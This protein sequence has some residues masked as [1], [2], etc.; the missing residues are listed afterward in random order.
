MKRL[1]I[2]LI[3]CI[4]LAGCNESVL[5]LKNPAQYDESTYYKT[6]NECQEAVAACYSVL[7]MRPFYARDWYFIFDL[8][9][10]QS[11]KTANLEAT[12]V[13]FEE[14]TYAPEND[15]VNWAW[16]GFYR[17]SM[18]ALVAIEKIEAW[19]AKSEDEIAYKEQLL[20]EAY[21]FHG[22]AYY[23]LSE[24][25]GDVPYHPSWVSIKEEPSKARMPYA[26][27]Q[28]K[29]EE[30]L[31]TAVAKLPESWNT[32][33]LG[34]VTK[35]AARAMLGKLYL[36]QGK[37]DEAIQTLNSIK[38]S[39]LNGDYYSLFTRGNHTS[40]EIIFQVLHKFWGW[41]D[42]NSY[43]MWGGKEGYGGKATN[44]GRHVEYGFNDWNNLTVP[45]SAVAKFTYMLEGKSYLDPRNQLLVYGDGTIGDGDF[46]GGKFN[47]KPNDGTAVTGYKWKKYCYYESAEHMNMDDGDYSS[48]LIRMA[49]VK[50]MLAEAYI[51]KG[52]FESAKTLINQVRDR[53]KA[54]PYTT[55]NAT[56]AFEILKTE[57]YIELFGEQH[58]W[59][60]LVRWDRLGKLD[61]IK[62]IGRNAK[63]YHKKFPI[64][65]SEKDTN[66]LLQIQSDGW[67]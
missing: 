47:Y 65:T 13:Q 9:D 21:F 11:V 46:A 16:R 26:E 2:L 53:V 7:T 19:E 29:V 43:Y 10:G 37:N 39:Q 58:Y 40:P 25:W 59:F 50:L 15:Y 35:D 56:N 62:E 42:G 55:I 34:R 14:Y 63:S 45:N 22:Y 18:R 64:P 54:T 36:T 66:P 49:D 4:S 48:I 61:M 67:N 28:P 44:C 24:L 51:G 1:I 27:V 30:A 60:D 5:D 23:Y 6:Q 3:G 17:M 41:G 57:R 20:G 31:K 8:L 32:D 33:N 52:D 12:L 38:A